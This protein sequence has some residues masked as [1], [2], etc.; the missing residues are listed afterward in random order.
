MTAWKQYT[1]LDDKDFKIMKKNLIIDSRRILADK[2]L[3]SE[4]HAIGIGNN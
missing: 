4:Y 2:K 3:K 1:K